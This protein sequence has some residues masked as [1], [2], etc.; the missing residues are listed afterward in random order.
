MPGTQE[1][2]REQVKKA[3]AI[4]LRPDYSAQIVLVYRA[5]E[6]DWSFPKGHV[7]EGETP[8]AACLRE[9]K[10]ETGLDVD[11]LT[12]LPDNTYIHKTGNRITTHMYLVR[13][14]G[15]D[16]IAEHPEDKIE[17]VNMREVTDRFAYDNLK[18]YFKDILPIIERAA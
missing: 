12:Q 5:K 16:I 1:Q 11:V 4:V 9:V 18:A 17:W 14:K 15:D 6:R 13:S 7:E 8:L 3:G 10:E 2:A